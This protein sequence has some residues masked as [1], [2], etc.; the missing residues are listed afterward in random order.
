M[1]TDIVGYS[2]LMSKD[3]KK[4]MNVLE[5]NREIHKY[6]I[7]QFNGEFIK[8]IGDGT[9]SIFQS[10]FDAVS[11]AIEIQ[12]ACCK[13]SA[14]TIRIGIHIGDIIVKDNDVF[15]DGVNIAS[16]I[17]AAGEPGEIYISERV[18]ED[19]KNKTDI[20]AKFIG[21]KTL[22]NIKFP[23]KVYSIFTGK[24][25]ALSEPVFS[26]PGGS[27]P[28]LR[29]SNIVIV[30]LL[31]M[32][33]FL[34][35]QKFF[36]KDKFED[37]KNDDGR[38]SIAV[39][40]FKNLSGDTLY[41]VWQAGFQNLLINTLTDSK[42]LSVRQFKTMYSA[43]DN[44][45][46]INY[47]SLTPSFASDLALKLNTKT[48]ILGSILKTGNKI[49]INAQLVNA[50]TEEIYKIYQIDGNTEDDIFALADSLSKNIK[51]YFEI[52][53]I[54]DEFGY[55]ENYELTK[56]NSSE[57]LRYYILGMGSFINFNYPVAI[58]WFE[59]AIEIDSNFVSAYFYLSMAHNN[60]G[61]RKEAIE[62]FNM[63]YNKKERLPLLEKLE[64]EWFRAYYYETPYEQ[65][66]YIK[67]ILEIE[68]QSV[69]YWYVL[70][71]AYNDLY[72][73][74][75]AIV[76]C[77]KALKICDNLDIKHHWVYIYTILGRGYHSVDN[78]SKEKEIYE[79]GLLVLPDHP[80]IIR[81]QAVCAI[82]LGDTKKAKEYL[83]V[84]KSIRKENY[85][86]TESDINSDVGKIYSEANLPDSAVKYFRLALHLEP[87]NP[88]FM[89]NLAWFFI[90]NDINMDEGMEF[91]DKALEIEPDNYLFLDTKG[92]G[93]YK[94]ARYNEAFEVLNTA[95]EQWPHYKHR[96]FQHLK[97]VENKMTS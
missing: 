71:L 36:T 55:T 40:P 89:Y 20:R 35:Y 95:W 23:V 50:E 10:S 54:I 3:E 70:G 88:G 68:D 34:L 83:S 21:E 22:K 24:K 19:I 61:Q 81:E 52:K 44:R 13:E 96:V 33:G 66:K 18:Y 80:D 7:K 90:D 57:A 60:T 46:D 91:I 92:W 93:L 76:P 17:E 37:I 48:F 86:W 79:R 12:K 25:E 11:C 30:V 2:A 77:E 69:M 1:F 58:D 31:I 84:Y 51:N 56:T 49:R 62:W 67:Q 75:K 43:V 5:K 15:G 64:L 97:E 82:S 74:S 94:Q 32:G 39:M 47:A 28:W 72:Q 65:I 42:E 45:E 27:K 9:L 59:K 38:I 73:Y 16:R 26:E 8:E 29:A 78:H 53:I 41:N 85:Q 87:S 6:A 14:L 4:A 63:A